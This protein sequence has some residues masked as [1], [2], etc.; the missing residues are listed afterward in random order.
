MYIT[1]FPFENDVT[2][3]RAQYTYTAVDFHFSL[4][5]GLGLWLKVSYPPPP[6][7]V[8]SGPSPQVSDDRYVRRPKR[9]PY[10][11]III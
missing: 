9:L 4:W 2:R 8:V 11:R 3:Q 1:V 10:T 5:C 6:Q 7:L